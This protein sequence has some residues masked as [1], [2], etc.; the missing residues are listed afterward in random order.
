MAKKFGFEKQIPQKLIVDFLAILQ[1]KNCDY[2]QSFFNLSD[3][4]LRR[5]PLI[6][7]GEE[8]HKWF[9]SW[10][11]LLQQ[12]YDFSDKNILPKI[13]KK[14]RAINPFIIARNHVVQEIIDAGNNLD[15]HP[16]EKFLKVLKKPFHFHEKNIYYHAPP[17]KE[18]RVSQTF[19]GT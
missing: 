4:L 16:L 19:C 12:E 17:S 18:Q 7:V 1:Q 6:I 9:S 15:F 5:E 8:Y 3:D 10:Q 14:M 2:H 13:A 11:N